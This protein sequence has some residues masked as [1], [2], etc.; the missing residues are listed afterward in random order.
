MS[1]GVTRAVKSSIYTQPHLPLGLM[2]ILQIHVKK[3]CS[4]LD[5][6]AHLAFIINFAY[7]ISSFTMM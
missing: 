2:S 5:K 6:H 1:V 3:E 7:T 4:V